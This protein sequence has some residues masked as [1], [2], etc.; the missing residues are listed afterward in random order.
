MLWLFGGEGFPA[1]GASGRL[2]DLWR[3]DPATGH[4]TWIKGSSVIDQNGIYGALGVPDEAN[5]PGG[6]A[7]AAAWT[8]GDGALWLFGGVGFPASGAQNHLNDLWRF[9]P[10]TGHWTWIKGANVIFQYGTYGTLG[11]ADVANTPGGR[12]NVVSWT[13]DDGV[14]WLFGGVGFDLSS[15]V[16]DHLNDLWRFD[17]GTGNW[18][19]IKGAN[20][21][22]QHGTYGTLGMA[23][24]ANTPGARQTPLSWTGGDG[25][26]WLLGGFGYPATGGTGR[27][28]DLWRFVFPRERLVL[29]AG[30]GSYLGNSI[31]PQTKAL[32]D[33]FHAAALERGFLPE[34]ITYLSAFDPPS[35]MT[36][37][38]GPATF[39]ALQGAIFNTQAL[40]TSRL[41]VVLLDHGS[42]LEGDAPPTDSE[43]LFHLDF[44]D[45]NAEYISADEL[46]L[47]LD[48]AQ[49][50]G[51]AIPEVALVVDTCFSGG[52]VRRRAGAPVGRDRVV[53]SG[54]TDSRLANFAGADGSLSFTGFFLP[55]LMSGASYLD[56]CEGAPDFLLE[57]QSP[58]DAPQFPWL[59]DDGDG[60]P[61]VADGAFAAMV[62]L[63]SGGP[64]GTA[65]PP[66]VSVK[67]DDTIPTPVNVEL[68]AV[69]DPGVV[70]QVTAFVTYEGTYHPQGAPV[71]SQ[72]V[73]PMALD[74]VTPDRWIAALPPSFILR[75]GPYRI[76]YLAERYD[77]LTGVLVPG[78][79]AFR[80]L[81][82]GDPIPLD[83]YDLLFN[84]NTVAGT[85]A[86]IQLGE[87]QFRTLHT[88]GD[89]DWVCFQIPQGSGNYTIRVRTAGVGSAIDPV[90]FVQRVSDSAIMTTD[91]F[92][93]LPGAVNC[94]GLGVS[95][96]VTLALTGGAYIMRVSHAI[97]QPHGPNASYYLELSG[98]YGKSV[99]IGVVTVKYIS[100]IGGGRLGRDAEGSPFGRSGPGAYP[101]TALEIPANALSRGQH[102]TFGV[103]FDGYSCDKTL[104]A[105]IEWF[106]RP[107]TAANHTPIMLNIGDFQ[108]GEGLTSFAPS[109]LILEMEFAETGLL[110]G[111]GDMIEDVPEGS[112]ATP[113][114]SSRGIRPARS[115]W[116]LTTR[117]S[118]S[119]AAS[120]ARNCTTSRRMWTRTTGTSRSSPSNRFRSSRYRWI[121]GGSNE[122]EGGRRKD[123]WRMAN[124]KSEC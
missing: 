93:G 45:G 101:R 62:T 50:G 80:K 81:T 106:D 22:G 91:C 41:H 47:L 88:S 111:C 30:G 123:E 98:G 86:Y 37:V 108:L 39:A 48:A 43:W 2:N 8:G 121:T 46:K 92:S 18:T 116:S 20:F 34:G 97:G 7:G 9:D 105:M 58:P 14:F 87:V 16:P 120:S 103:P 119:A 82:V 6:R 44:T 27:L 49:S 5:M 25:A 113:R 102:V 90:L 76:A 104:P 56:A 12:A 66:F 115:G 17:P 53:V 52:F 89:L 32:A 11:V 79:P 70:T 110:T 69:L 64:A 83:V 40:G 68:W 29:V 112:P 10:A 94:N 63:G 77:P 78:E 96:G 42:Y 55:A 72:L 24:A 15:V 36:G 59:D 75:P 118:G 73:L 26:L 21:A 3:F 31:A 107:V 51:V 67:P 85:T 35:A 38:D 99:G 13:G 57:L 71:A 54:T 117:R 60:A 19:W 124:E 84:D 122:R 28:N 33:R 95:E 74:G 1:S 65:P 114:G 4:W 109:S 23:D 61:T 100:D